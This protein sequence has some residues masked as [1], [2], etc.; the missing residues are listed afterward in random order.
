MNFSNERIDAHNNWPINKSFKAEVIFA[1]RLLKNGGAA[2]FKPISINQNNNPDY[3]RCVGH[4][5]DALDQIPNRPDYAFDHFF[6]IIDISGRHLFLNKGIKGIVQGASTKLLATHGEDWKKVVDALCAAMPLRTYELLAKRLLKAAS[7]QSSENDSLNKRALHVMGQKFYDA[8]IKKYTLD[9]SGN[10]LANAADVNRANAAKLLKLYMSGKLGTRSKPAS[11]DALDLTKEVNIPTYKQRSE[12]I[13][14]LLLFTIRNERAHGNVI[15]PFRTSKATI[16][17]YESYYFI[18]LLSYI[19][20]LGILSLR[21]NCISSN[22]I[23]VGC[24]NNIEVQKSFFI[25]DQRAAGDLVS[26]QS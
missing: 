21:F 1:K 6:R 9:S 5:L 24:S 2:P 10:P 15:S 8:F 18:M 3:Q 25:S 19:Y 16:E 26:S 13:L 20:S 17:R 22:D 7:N 23:F 11:N 4:L 12:V 14:S